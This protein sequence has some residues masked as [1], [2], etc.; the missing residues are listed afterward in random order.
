MKGKY[1]TLEHVIRAEYVQVRLDNRTR[2]TQ[3]YN[4]WQYTIRVIE[5]YK[6]NNK[7]ATGVNS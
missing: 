7:G 6:R 5:I 2:I 1:L 3:C 4:Q